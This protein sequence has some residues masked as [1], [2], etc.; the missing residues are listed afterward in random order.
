MDYTI[1]ILTKE[2]WQVLKDLWLEALQANPEAYGSSYEEESL[3]SDE[4]WKKKF[5][6]ST[7]YVARIG[8]TYVGLMGVQFEKKIKV[9]H[10]AQIVGVYVTAKE[11]GRGIGRAMMERALVDLRAD[12]KIIRVGIGVNILQKNAVQLYHDLGFKDYG[13]A[14]KASRIGDTYYDH[15]QMQL[16]F[17][18]KFTA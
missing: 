16:I 14:E 5:D 1:E 17:E 6:A 12:P 2:N 9:A 11:R 8:D 18:D 13:P 3:L 15:M 7:K 10:S 4:E